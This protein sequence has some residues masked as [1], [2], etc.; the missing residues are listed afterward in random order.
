LIKRALVSLLFVF[1]LVGCGG[2]A[3]QNSEILF[4]LQSGSRWVYRFRGTVKL[5]EVAGGGTINARESESSLTWEVAGTATDPNNPTVPLTILDR[6]YDIVL[7]DG[8]RIRANQRLYLTQTQEGIFVHGINFYPGETFVPTDDKF[9]PSTHNPP[10]KFLYLPNPVSDS[11]SAQYSRPLSTAGSSYTLNV[12]SGFQSVETPT[13]QFFAKPI[14]W[15]EKFI[16]VT[17]GDFTLTQ[18]GIVPDLGLV[19]G[20]LDAVLPDDTELHGNIYLIF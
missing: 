9:V 20:R 13:D 10:F 16:K 18:G 3:K 5:P 12:G 11:F 1:A 17:A 14:E 7:A 2:G 15:Q 19:V 4:S 6:K 8:R